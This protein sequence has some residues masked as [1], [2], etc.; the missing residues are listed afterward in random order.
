MIFYLHISPSFSPLY[1]PFGG[2]E[3]SPGAEEDRT[4]PDDCGARHPTLQG[5]AVRHPAGGS[6]GANGQL[7]VDLK[8]LLKWRIYH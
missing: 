3:E 7:L 6:Q 4:I 5:R 2:A 8:N 1:V